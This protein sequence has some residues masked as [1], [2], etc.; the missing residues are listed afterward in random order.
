MFLTVRHVLTWTDS[1][2]KNVLYGGVVEFVAVTPEKSREKE[3]S[4]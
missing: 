1:L 4:Q 2:S 3:N